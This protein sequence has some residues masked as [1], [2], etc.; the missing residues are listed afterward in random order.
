MDYHCGVYAILLMKCGET[1]TQ[2]HAASTHAASVY[3]SGSDAETYDAS[4]TTWPMGLDNKQVLNRLLVFVWF[5]LAGVFGEVV[6]L[7]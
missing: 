6:D 2:T 3:K 7:R 4:R 1:V 5:C